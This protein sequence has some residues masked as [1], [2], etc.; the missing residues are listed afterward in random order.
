MDGREKARMRLQ[1]FPPGVI[2][3]PL[4]ACI[5]PARISAWQPVVAVIFSAS[6]FAE[7]NHM[8]RKGRD[9]LLEV[10]GRPPWPVGM[11]FGLAGFAVF[12]WGMGWYVTSVGGAIGKVFGKAILSGGLEPVAWA[13][14]GLGFVG[15]AMSAYR[16][17]D[18][19]RLLDEQGN[20]ESLR[21]LSWSR[22]EQFV[23]EAFRRQGYSVEE[24]GQGGADGG[25]D[26]VLRKDGATTL[27]QCKQWRSRQVG[28]SVVREMFGLLHHH[29][30]AAVKIVCTGVFSS[31]CYRFAVG[32]SLELVDGEALLALIGRST[33]I[34]ELTKVAAGARDARKPSAV[35]PA[36]PKCAGEMMERTNRASG[37]LF[38]GCTGYPRC[39]GTVSI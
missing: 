21:A 31:A 39:R 6:P 12:R 10:L 27:V 8:A 35:P 13:L 19:A 38:W 30:A 7:G 36:C 3:Q 22:F 17:R 34:T 32:K 28:V 18:R 4:A 37:Q 1:K 5:T 33:T 9:G 14:L 29:Q 26:L 20:L 2:G 25:I 16:R 23:G 15:A 24:T 11:V